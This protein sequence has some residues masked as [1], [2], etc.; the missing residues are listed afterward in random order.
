[1]PVGTEIHDAERGHLLRDLVAEGDRCELAR[2]GRGGRGNKRFASSVQ[3]A[4]RRAEAGEPGEARRVRLELKLIAEVGLVGLPN[5]G[6]ST[7]LAAVS[8]AKPR[9]ADYPFTTLFPQVGIAAVDADESLVLADLP[10]LIEGAARGAGLGHRFLRHVERCQV[11]LHMVDVSSEA[12][13]DPEEAR[14]VVAR[15]IAEYSALLA[16][17]PRLLVASK[18]EDEAAA[19]RARELAARSGEAVYPLSTWTG[20]GV[21][22]LLSAALATV[23]A[24]GKRRGS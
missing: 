23:R 13:C 11:L 7:F 19:R 3:Q 16:L 22:E 8:Q 14:Q 12:G 24:G 10:G 1:V 5:S 9:V 21:K 15:E 17:R 6:K 4:P 2:G 20:A 18:C